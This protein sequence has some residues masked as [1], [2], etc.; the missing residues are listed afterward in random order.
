MS[1]RH[2]APARRWPILVALAWIALLA[3]VWL[4]IYG[5]VPV[6]R[7]AGLARLARELALLAFVLGAAYG[8]GRLALSGWHTP[9]GARP[10]PYFVAG[11][12]F[13]VLWLS[14][15]AVAA[16]QLL[17]PA[18]P[19]LLLGAGWLA[20]LAG[21]GPGLLRFRSGFHAALRAPDLSSWTLF[22]WFLLL[23]MV[24]SL[25][26]SLLAWALVPPLAWDEISYHLP[27]P[28]AYIRAGGL[29]NLPAIVHSNWPAGMEM[30]DTLAL[31]MGSEVLPH[32]IVTAMTALTALGLA[33]LARRLL[34]RGTAR[35]AAALYLS[36]P[37]VKY[38]AGVALIEGALG[39]YGLLAIWSGFAWLESRDR[40]DLVLAGLLGG[41]TASIKLTGAALP[42][43]VGIVGLAW[44]VLRARREPG[45]ALAHF[46][47]YGLVA[48]LVVTPWYVKSTIYTGNPIWPFAFNVLGGR[49]WDV[50]GD[51]IHNAFLHLPNLAPTLKNYVAGLW[52]LTVRW[53]QFGGL[54]LGGAILALAP[55]SLLFWRQKR[56]LLGYL[57]AVSAG[58]YT[59]WFLTTHQTRFLM[60]IV[61]VLALLAAYA[62]TR[63]T[64]DRPPWLAALAEVAMVLYLAVGLPFVDAGQRALI[65][66]R[67]PYVAGHISR[68]EFL[69]G[70]VNGY[71]AFE[72]A[73]E[74]LP[75]DA[76]VLLATFETRGYYLDRATIWANPVG[77]R[78]FKWEQFATARDA[79]LF[80]HAQGVTHI[81]WNDG[82]L[83]PNVANEEYTARLLRSLLDEYGRPL[84]NAEG[85]A[86]YELSPVP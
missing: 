40:R 75:P 44:M 28:R 11:L 33:A 42:L 39:F 36:M 65:G 34:D 7:P 85:F 66:D 35:L 68:R 29:V 64:A 6:P 77:Q 14:T 23:V 27:I 80:L 60:G 86:I 59:A 82:L 12:G 51:Q 43:A 8:W 56:G 72:Y 71:P 13:G 41:L 22:D 30:L 58:V 74:H 3:V 69:A 37:M 19:W 54:R 21:A 10:N 9:H 32:L 83:I 61:P 24:F 50:T 18:W 70:H 67:W 52:Y 16:L 81:F 53:P 63:L 62:F 1:D 47:A 55:L 79:A 26:Y 84:Y 45:R 78:L 76:L 20:L 2:D 15:L 5:R 17:G 25:G 46:V 38:L 48:F 57:V 4:W 73:N 49:N 31:L